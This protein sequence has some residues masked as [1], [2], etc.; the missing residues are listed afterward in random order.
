MT[1]WKKMNHT[2]EHPQIYTDI[3]SS[4]TTALFKHSGL[5]LQCSWN[6]RVGV[7]GT[8]TY[9]QLEL[10]WNNVVGTNRSLTSHRTLRPQNILNINSN[11]LKLVTNT[12]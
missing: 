6:Y 8:K 5:Y 11:I 12:K 1:Y 2:V 7:A 3:Y 9:L 4:A 10:L